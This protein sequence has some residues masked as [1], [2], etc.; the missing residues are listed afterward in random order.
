MFSASG[1]FLLAVLSFYPKNR[2]LPSPENILT[3]P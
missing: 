3:L 1:D 2:A